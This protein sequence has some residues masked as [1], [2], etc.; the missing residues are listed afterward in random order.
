MAGF[1]DDGWNRDDGYIKPADKGDNGERVHDGLS[2]AYRPVTRREIILLEQKLEKV[3]YATIDDPENFE[4]AAMSCDF[5]AKHVQSWDLKD[6]NGKVVPINAT[7]MERVHPY[8]FND[9]YGIIT[10]K[11]TSD[12]KPAATEPPKSDDENLKNSEAASGSS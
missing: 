3:R 4:A 8:L 10:Q 2:F 12:K 9:L 7:T 6:R 5:V 1:I 11:R